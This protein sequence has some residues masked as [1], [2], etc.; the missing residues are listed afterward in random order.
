MTRAAWPPPLFLAAVIATS[1]WAQM[2]VGQSPVLQP[3]VARSPL[4]QDVL[5]P[6]KKRYNAAGKPRILLFWNA[7]FDDETEAPH[8]ELDVLKKSESQSGTDLSKQTD[9]PAGAATLREHDAKTSD[10]EERIKTT[11]HT[12]PAKVQSNLDARTATRLEATFRQQLHAAGIVLLDRS[13]SIRFT[14]ALRDRDHVDPKLIEADA[15]VK[16]D[17]LLEILMMPDSTAPLG[18]GFKVSAINVKDGS[19]L[20]TFYALGRP[21]Q[22]AQIGHYVA[23]EDGFVWEQPKPPA[24]SVAD[25]AVA[26]VNDVLQALGPVLPERMAK[27]R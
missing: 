24:P 7:A 1:S 8:Q 13:S 20:L 19:E 17:L 4:P 16:A 26:L 6:F 5:T 22:A 15:V 10:K 14:Q 3:P 23:T 2:R 27:T 18:S 25:I 9:G 11:L 21:F 12:D